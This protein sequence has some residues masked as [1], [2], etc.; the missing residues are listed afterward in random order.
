[1][2]TKI[3]KKKQTNGKKLKHLLFIFP[4]LLNHKSLSELSDLENTKESFE[5]SK[6]GGLKILR[7]F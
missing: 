5:K 2:A 4:F 7:K 3:M 6:C 1:M